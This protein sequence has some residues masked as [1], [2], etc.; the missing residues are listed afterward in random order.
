VL[1]PIDKKF[2]KEKKIEKVKIEEKPGSDSGNHDFTRY[3]IYDTDADQKDLI[4][5]K[6]KHFDRS[7]PARKVQSTTDEGS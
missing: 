7:G 2:I 4:H 6:K 1:P 5:N 3:S